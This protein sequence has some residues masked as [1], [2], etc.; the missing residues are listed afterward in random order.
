[1]VLKSKEENRVLAV[2]PEQSVYEAI[3]QMAEHG[4]GRCWSFLSIDWLASCRSVTTR[5]R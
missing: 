3:E 1:M 5:A 4:V 2:T